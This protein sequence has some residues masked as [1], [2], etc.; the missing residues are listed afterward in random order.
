MKG[1]GKGNIS[2]LVENAPRLC[3]EQNPAAKLTIGQVTEIRRRY[4]PRQISMKALATE[5][6]VNPA[7]IFCIV[8]NITWRS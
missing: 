6:K 2:K 7:A 3:G 8:H 1:R 5:F 4:V